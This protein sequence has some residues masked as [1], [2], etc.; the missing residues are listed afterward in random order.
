VLHHIWLIQF[1][2]LPL[3]QKNR[4]VLPLRKGN[5]TVFD[6]VQN[7]LRVEGLD[8]APPRSA[9]TI[10]FAIPRILFLPVLLEQATAVS[11]PLAT[12]NWA[13]EV[14]GEVCQFVSIPVLPT[15]Q[16]FRAHVT[17]PL[18]TRG[19]NGWC[20]GVPEGRG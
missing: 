2:A 16:R 4:F 18:S 1:T 8:L 10:R 19:R 3:N 12:R 20:D 6:L 15:G 13:V 5:G 14:K 17:L 11:A 7:L 9:A